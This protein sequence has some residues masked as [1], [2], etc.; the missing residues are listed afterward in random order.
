MNSKEE[1]PLIIPIKDAPIQFRIF[2]SCYGPKKSKDEAI[3]SIIN[4]LKIIGKRFPHINKKFDDDKMKQFLYKL[5]NDKNA[6]KKFMYEMDT[7]IKNTI[8]KDLKK[9]DKDI[10]QKIRTNVVQLE[11]L[12]FP[13]LEDKETYKYI[14]EGGLPHWLKS[15]EHG[16]WWV[17]LGKYADLEKIKLGFKKIFGKF[18]KIVMWIVLY[19]LFPIWTIQQKLNKLPWWLKWISWMHAGYIFFI[20]IVLQI[21]TFLPKPFGWIFSLITIAFSFMKF[22]LNGVVAGLLTIIPILGDAAGGG[23]KVTGKVA[24]LVEFIFKPAKVVLGWS[25]GLVDII[26]FGGKFDKAAIEISEF[27]LKHGEDGVEIIELFVKSEGKIAK[28]SQEIVNF[29]AKH[30]KL[31]L[32]N[33]KEVVSVGETIA[34]HGSKYGDKLL[35]LVKFGKSYPGKVAAIVGTGTTKL[36]RKGVKYAE[37]KAIEIA[38]EKGKKYIESV[39]EELQE[40]ALKGISIRDDDKVPEKIYIKDQGGGLPKLPLSNNIK[41]YQ[42]EKLPKLPLSNDIKKYQYKLPKLPKLSLSINI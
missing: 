1:K 35:H 34:E 32:K 26:K 14:Q 13:I 37:A 8:L 41:K 10:E 22:D 27:F 11:K 17:I 39:Q 9:Y 31:I 25:E 19:T 3:N 16:I 24:K 29:L 42:Y 15:V 5:S 23:L 36:T 28:G 40:K 21:L 30:E 18:Y 6:E 4:N 12:A 33:S 7:Y 2:L 20:D 38:K